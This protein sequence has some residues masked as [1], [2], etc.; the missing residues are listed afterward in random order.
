MATVAMAAAFL[1]AVLCAG[2]RASAPEA[3]VVFGAASLQETLREVGE[4]WTQR[5]GRAVRFQFGASSTLARQLALGA[6]A[7]LF[8]SADDAWAESVRPIERFAWLGNRLVLVAPAGAPPLDLDRLPGLA[9]GGEGTPIGKYT[10]TA[11]EQLGIP[12]PP[13]LVYGSN[14]RDV[15]TKVA[16]GA[17][18][19]GVVY[20]TDVPLEPRVRRVR[21][22]PVET[23]VVAA[24][25]TPAGR[26]LFSDLRQPWALECA[27]RR[28]FRTP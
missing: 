11:F 6:H 16:A 24:L 27:R 20:E 22:L 14:V 3:V 25:L 28:G 18:P 13:R 19:A 7:D 4:A 21:D 23:T 12:L 26:D 5:R 9:L 8:V 15:L 1:A 17:A 10:R 2:G